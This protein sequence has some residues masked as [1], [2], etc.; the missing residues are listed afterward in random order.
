MPDDER[1][2]PHRRHR[3]DRVPQRLPLGHRRALRADVD[4]VGREPL[5]RQLERRPGPGRILEEQV[6]HGPPAQR[7]Q[8]LHRSDLHLGHFFGEVEDDVH[9]VGVEVRGGQQVPH[10][11][12]SSPG[13]GAPVGL[14]VRVGGAGDSDL[15]DAVHFGQADAHPFVVTG[16]QVG[17]DVIGPDRQ[18]AMA[19]VHQDGQADRAR[20][21][22]VAE[23]IQRRPHRTP[24]VEHVV[25]Q[26]DHGAVDGE[27]DFGS[28]HRPGGLTLQI[29]AVHRHVQR[30]DRDARAFGLRDG[31]G[32]SG[33][34]RDAAGRDA[35]QDQSGAAAV[36]LQHLMRHSG[37]DP[38]ELPGVQ[39]QPG[40]L[41]DG[42]GPFQSTD[43]LR[44]ATGVVALRERAATPCFPPRPPAS[45]P[46]FADTVEG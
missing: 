44:H 45:G 42:G 16:Q 1:V 9:R 40:R 3:Q 27:R 12:A 15:A 7:R 31:P 2:H 39:H 46:T 5:A 38:M 23:R 22:Q 36:G 35:Q 10:Q 24:G 13:R 14:G 21:P 11:T 26:D 43:G 29:V 4:H 33:G 17:A 41:G 30:S 37:T 34:Q 25:D 8:L 18:F 32:Q 20:A 6:H 28:A 19:A